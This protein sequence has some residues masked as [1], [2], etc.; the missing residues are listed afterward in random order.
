MTEGPRSEPLFG[1]V[2]LIGVGLIGSS[3]AH[4]IRK[5]GLARRVVAGVRPGPS[6]ETLKR[7][8]I[9]DAVVEDLAEAVRDADLVILCTPVGSYGG[10]AKTIAPHLKP[11]AILSDV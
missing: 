9:T 6:A 2:T 5:N 10:I 11:G 4:V 7:M 8:N 3:L 1:T